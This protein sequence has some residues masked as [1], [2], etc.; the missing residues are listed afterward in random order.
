MNEPGAAAGSLESVLRSGRF[1]F[2]AEATPPP[3]A[4]PDDMARRVAPLVGVADAVNVTDAASARAHM[5]ALAA[6]VLAARAGLD[7]V[8]QMTLRD[9]NRLALQGDLLGAA[10]LGVRNVLCLTGD[11]MAAGDQPGAREVFDLDSAGLMAMARDMGETQR[12]P[13]GRALAAMPRLF[14]GAADSPLDP[15]A[16]WRPAALER[17]I[18]SGARFVQTQ[19]CFDAGVVRRYAG[20]LADLGIAERAWLLI[21]VGPLR[22]ARSARWMNGNLFGVH[23][24]EPVVRRLEG[25]RDAEEEGVRVCVELIE[26]MRGMPGVAGA[27]VMGPRSE[28]TAAEAIRRVRA[29]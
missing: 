6:A 25:A 8:M 24:P 9:R 26:E 4:D 2:T 5:G 21:G 27:H 17:K 19:F 29:G 7:P 3:S 22:S 10:A 14:I 11:R 12:L 20:R 28:A 16:D 15:P 18:A 13:G 1:A 23:V